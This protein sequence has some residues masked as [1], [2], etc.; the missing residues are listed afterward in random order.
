MAKLIDNRT[1]ALV[2]AGVMRPVDA[3]ILVTLFGGTCT[4]AAWVA[5]GQPTALGVLAAV[6]GLHLVASAWLVLLIF[7][8]MVL[9]IETKS[10]INLMPESAARLVLAYGRASPK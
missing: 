7:R 10:A 1:R 8:A 2:K 9:V 6:L 3:L 5:F 4:L